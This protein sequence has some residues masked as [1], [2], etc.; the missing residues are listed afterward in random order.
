MSI[1]VGSDSRPVHVVPQS[2][3]LPQL[4]RLGLPPHGGAR[5]QI[6]NSLQ[7][8]ASPLS[9]W[10]RG[11]ARRFGGFAPSLLFHVGR[12]AMHHFEV[13]SVAGIERVAAM[14]AGLDLRL[15]SHV[16]QGTRFGPKSGAG[17]VQF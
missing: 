2:D 10:K 16:A 11:S 15:G 17:G 14:Y 12:A 9:W 13:V 7:K 4:F 3:S 1:P 8:V 5:L 6:A